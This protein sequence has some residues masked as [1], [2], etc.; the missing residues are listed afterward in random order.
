VDDRFH[1]VLL[2][3]TVR[4]RGGGRVLTARLPTGTVTFL[5]T[6]IEGSTRLLR[7][8]GDDYRA[9]QDDQM[10][11]I[12]EAIVEG[13]GTVI[14]TE[15]DAFFV[16]FPTATGAVRTATQAQRSFAAHPWTH[17]EPLRVRIG[18]HTGEGRL[19][20]D[21]YLGID[22]NR[23]ARIAAAAHG[24]QV[25]V[26]EATHALVSD[27]LADGV[28]IRD[29]GRHR[30]KDFDAP[31]RIYQLV[32][33]DLPSDFPAIRSL[34]VPTNLPM[35]LT[36]FVG[37]EREIDSIS[38][39]LS[40]NR[41]I[42][43][44]GPGGSGKTRLAVEVARRSTDHPDGIYFVDLAPIRDP[45]LVAS[46]IVNSLGLRQ[47]AGRVALETVMGH[48]ADR[49]ALVLMDNFE[50]VIAA[51]PVVE[52]ILRAAPEVKVVVTSRIR[53]GLLG[54]QEFPVPPLGLPEDRSDLAK[55]E[56]NEA[57]ALF[58]ERAR[59]VLPSFEI[60]HQNAEAVA[61]IC[62]RVD[63][64]PLAIELAAAQVRL[65]TPSELLSRLQ[66]RL[67]LRTGAGNVPER[68]RTLR[69]TI[70]WSYQLLDE[71]QRRLFARLSA[72]AGGGT[73]PAIEAICN[74][75][76]DLGVE[77][78]EGLAALL[79]HSLIRREEFPEGSRFSMLETIREFAAERLRT[80]FDLEET[81]GGHAEFF[82][83]F[84][85]RWGP[86]V[87]SR[88]ALEATSVLTR[89]HD[90]VRAAVDWA[91]RTDQAEV[92]L[93]IVAPMW[94]FWVEQG[95]LGEGFKAIQ[96]V[97]EL[98]SGASLHG[99]RAAAVRALA[100]L[101]YWQNDYRAASQAY[102]EAMDLY[103]RLGDSRGLV[104]TGNDLAYAL[105][106]QGDP[107]AA[108]PLI[109]ASLEAA[110]ATDDTG[111]AAHV[112]GLLGLALIQRGDYEGALAA[113]QESREGLEAVGG[114]AA[115]SLGEATGRVGA[116]LRLIGRLDEAEQYMVAGLLLDRSL[117]SNLG[118]SA[119]SRHL[120]AVAWDRGDVERALRFGGFSQVTAERI[121][122]IPP[123]ALMFV[124]DPPVYREWARARLD[125]E[126]IERLWAEGRAMSLDEAIAYATG[127]S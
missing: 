13:G 18:I 98:P 21:D 14:R 11:L 36:G 74:P 27:A 1:G 3:R 64:L 68:Q 58:R 45:E 112:T 19:G 126:T 114:P 47:Q 24:G 84:V 69:G 51:A 102:Q 119:I 7:A 65:L 42:T 93:R 95:H 94:M 99:G 127:G 38:A 123:P 31:H 37:R 91:L 46:T 63:G 20:G 59:A 118:A 32:I 81:E 113:L 62:A 125:E 87:R 15:G 23:A 92:G 79:D 55:M 61:E 96:Q 76:Q 70:D 39:L 100:S 6:D 107:E 48:L 111:L 56:N 29:L 41:L 75:G 50:Q 5:F 9:V 10:R 104:Q 4:A 33:L 26:S 80:E 44:A 116:I 90:N 71:P 25:L 105:L 40:R 122:G 12:R 28:T 86:A 43:L 124:P 101:A 52:E 30:L 117:G 22:V 97:L 53:L 110:R 49:R 109:E 106:A 17:G 83:A 108:L 72:F 89:D 120:A 73:L 54:E 2:V 34:E 88:I 66:H 67:P 82:A 8:L 85:E 16:V 78:L 115:I 121:G 35:Q 103:R 77:T 60:D 57:V